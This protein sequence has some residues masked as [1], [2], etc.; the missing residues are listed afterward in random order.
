MW[1][2]S[3]SKDSAPVSKDADCEH[4]EDDPDGVAVG[5]QEVVGA[6]AWDEGHGVDVVDIADE[7]SSAG[8]DSP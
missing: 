2:G 4:A 3:G 5:F 8:A 1:S 6:L 7:P